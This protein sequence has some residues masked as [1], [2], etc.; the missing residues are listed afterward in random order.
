MLGL[1]VLVLKSK[2][3]IC[4]HEASHCILVSEL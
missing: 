4:V 1:G 2:P 3:M